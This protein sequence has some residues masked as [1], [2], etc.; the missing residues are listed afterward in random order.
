[1]HPPKQKGHGLENKTAI[2]FHR[3]SG[4]ADHL[5]F[6]DEFLADMK[7]LQRASVSVKAI[8]PQMEPAAE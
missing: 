7:A 3:T 4:T 8:V 1:M 6:A 2:V 5:A